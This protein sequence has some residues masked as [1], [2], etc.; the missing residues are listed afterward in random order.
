MW[1][2]HYN[3]V[4]PHSVGLSSTSAAELDRRRV[5]R[6]IQLAIEDQPFP[7]NSILPIKQPGSIVKATLPALTCGAPA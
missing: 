6:A 3:T 5:A 4:Y 1:R 2:T 7:L